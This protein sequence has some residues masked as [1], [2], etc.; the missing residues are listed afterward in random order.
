MIN[1]S[2]FQTVRARLLAL[3][4][5]III[6]IA[7]LSIILATTTYRSVNKSIEASQIQTVSSYAVRARVWFRSGLR[8]LVTAVESVRLI[9]A[10][11][12]NCAALARG[13]LDGIPGFEAIR[14]AIPGRPVCHASRRENITDTVMDA[15]AAEQ[16]AKPLEPSWGGPRTADGRY[17]ATSVGASSMISVGC[18]ICPSCNLIRM[19]LEV[20]PRIT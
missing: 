7:I 18:V 5:F 10:G 3:M 4:A 19:R 15:I 2:R 9:P 16:L 11:T 20:D 12:E 13:I 1:L 8:T 14:I 17:G 6:P